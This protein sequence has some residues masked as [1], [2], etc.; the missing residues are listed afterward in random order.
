MSLLQRVA[1][2]IVGVFALSLATP[3]AAQDGWFAYLLNEGSPNQLI[4]VNL[5]GETQTVDL[6][7][8][9]NNYVSN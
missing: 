8:S 9:E 1:I 4:R 3:A 7:L 6:G 5:A 2:L